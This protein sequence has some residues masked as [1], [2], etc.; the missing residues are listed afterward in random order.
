MKSSSSLLLLTLLLLTLLSLLAG[1][2]G[3]G[4]DPSP[5]NSS[6]LGGSVL[7]SSPSDSSASDSSP[8]DSSPSDLTTRGDPSV[9]NQTSA[10]PGSSPTPEYSAT[11]GP[12][13]PP[14]PAL[15]AHTS[16]AAKPAAAATTERC[17]F[18]RT[19]GRVVLMV[20]GALTVA[21]VGL[22]VTTALLTWKL[23]QRRREAE[24]D[25]DLISNSE[26]WMGS[27]RRN[28]AKPPP[29]NDTC[30]LLGLLETKEGQRG[31]GGAEGGDGGEGGEAGEEQEGKGGEGEV[32]AEA[33]GTAG[34]LAPAGGPSES[35]PPADP[36]LGGGSGEAV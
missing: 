30:L 20:A 14:S 1:V 9:S 16:T 12:P 24:P 26:F 2:R 23:C 29:A 33:N 3:E 35:G 18:P 19:Q 15:P 34:V 25:S 31:A 32:D 36:C 11:D 8:S 5:S 13:P 22:L 7:N 27:A 10:A 28:K 21:C 6:A 17:M 4:P